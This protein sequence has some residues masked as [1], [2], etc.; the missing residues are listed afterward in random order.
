MDEKLQGQI[1][2]VVSGLGGAA[3]AFGVVAQEDVAGISNAI[4]AGAGAIA[5]L[6]AAAWSIIN[7]LR[8]SA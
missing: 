1:R 8:G 7:K 2:H 6:A 5:Y 3:V 4:I